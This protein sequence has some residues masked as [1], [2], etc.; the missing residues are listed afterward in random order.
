[1]A[2]STS[3]TRRVL[4]LASSGAGGDLPPLMAVAVG[5]RERGVGLLF[6]GDASVAEAARGLDAESDV[7]VAPRE[8]DLGPVIIGAIRDTQGRPEAERGQVMR[9]RIAEWSAG[10]AALVVETLRARPCDLVLTSLF[11]TGAADL[12][13]G[14]MALPW[15]VVNST[16]YVGP[17]PPRPLAMDFSARAVP[18]FEY[19]VPPLERAARVLH[20]TDQAFDFGYADLPPHHRYAGPLL[21]EPPSA[22]APAYLDEPGDPWVLATI[23]SQLQDDQALGQAVLDGLAEQPVRV[24]LTTGGTRGADAFEVPPNA[25]VEPYV[26]HAAALRKSA[27]FVSHAGHGS[28]MKALTHGVPMVLVPWGRDQPGV[29]ARAE[30]LGVAVVVRREGLTPSA[31]SE[32]TERVLAK[33]SYARTAGVHAERLRQQDPRAVACDEVVAVPKW[34]I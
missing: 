1:M 13:A 31:L 27:V 12:A 29:A 15:V 23:S 11:G 2:T 4:V 19:L 10:I 7:V 32:A 16:F 6:V 25:R 24:L 20:A 26:S 8:H 33:P 9:Q 17:R 18:L 21:W 3:H 22:S 14:E 30:H 34:R 5:L 28:V